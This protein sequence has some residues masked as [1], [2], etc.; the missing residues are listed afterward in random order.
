MSIGQI[1]LFAAVWLV[2]ATMV[3]ESIG[4]IKPWERKLTKPPVVRLLMIVLA[5]IVCACVIALLA[6]AM[7]LLLVSLIPAALADSLTKAFRS[8]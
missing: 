4:N 3:A 7:L 8:A 1:L 5:P 2:T 6:V